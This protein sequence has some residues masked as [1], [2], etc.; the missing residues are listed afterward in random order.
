MK[1]ENLITKTILTVGETQVLLSP[2]TKFDMIWVGFSVS[3]DSSALL[4]SSILI[5]VKNF[6]EDNYGKFIYSVG[7]N[8][9]TATS[10][11]FIDA[12]TIKFTSK[13][14]NEY[15]LGVRGMRF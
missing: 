2:I 3:N 9:D 4:V 14:A 7:G 11:A 5:P 13:I 15:V 10:I 8:L 12:N 6:L 1:S